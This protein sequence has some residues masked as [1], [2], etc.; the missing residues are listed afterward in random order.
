LAFGAIK[1]SP[2]SVYNNDLEKT[3]PAAFVKFTQ[4]NLNDIELMETVSKKIPKNF[5]FSLVSEFIKD[6]L[7]DCN[8][9]FYGLVKE[10][11]CYD[12]VEF[13][14]ILGFVETSDMFKGV[15]IDGIQSWYCNTDKYS[16]IGT[17]MLNGVL[18]EYKKDMSLFSD[19]DTKPFYEH[20]G[21]EEIQKLQIPYC[22]KY[23]YSNF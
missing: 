23:Y 19:E 11:Q 22:M 9:S 15:F 6:F 12:K 1:L 10:Q 20:Y 4:G 7:N 2:H 8:F 21:F 13:D 14:N 18:V 5:D 17:A 3:I 16:G